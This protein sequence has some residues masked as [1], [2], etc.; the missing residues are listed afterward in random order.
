MYE[1]KT[2]NWKDLPGNKYSKAL[3]AAMVSERGYITLQKVRRCHEPNGAMCN[4]IYDRDYVIQF[5]IKRVLYSLAVLGKETVDEL[6]N[7]AWKEL[8]GID[9]ASVSN[10]VAS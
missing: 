2:I 10:D 1:Y 9:N 8:H 6:I 4:V 5:L 3:D 7:D